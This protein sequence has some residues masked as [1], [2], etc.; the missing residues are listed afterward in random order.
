V[1]LLV[2]F[3]GIVWFHTLSRMQQNVV[4]SNDQVGPHGISLASIQIMFRIA[5]S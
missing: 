2:R 5:K 1:K 4:L 3:A